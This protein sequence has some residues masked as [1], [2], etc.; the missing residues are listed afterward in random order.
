MSHRALTCS[1]SPPLAVALAC[2]GKKD[3]TLCSEGERR[4]LSGRRHGT[5]P[6]AAPR[7]QEAPP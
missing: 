2:G 1:S 3:E 7:P 4:R 5:A 6:A